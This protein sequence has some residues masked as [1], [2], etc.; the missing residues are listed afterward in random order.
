[1]VFFLIPLLSLELVWFGF[2]S[3][4]WVF[5]LCLGF[6]LMI[7][8]LSYVMGFC[9]MLW[10]L[11]LC[12]GF[13]LMFGFLSYVM[14]SCLMVGFLSYDMGSCLMICSCLV[15]LSTYSLRILV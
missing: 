3:Y 1:M 15:S 7:G 6:C 9:L 8:F 14:G 13:C 12:L 10:V 11:V 5:V 2:L 4:D